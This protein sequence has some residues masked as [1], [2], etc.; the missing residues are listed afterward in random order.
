MIR[1]LVCAATLLAALGLTDRTA[2]AVRS[3]IIPETTARRHGLTRPWFTQIQLD[4]GRARVSSILLHEE[5]LYV[6]TD[7]AMVH[8]IDGETG[9]TLWTRQVGRPGHPSLTP[10]ANRDY[11]ACINGSHLYVCNRYN[12]D[13]LFEI[14]VGGAPGAGPAV[15]EKR[16]YVPMVNGLVIAYRLESL[17][18]P[19]YELGKV[20][21]GVTEEEKAALE[22]NR[23]ENLRLRQEYIPPLACQ[24]IGRTLVQP[25][26]TR[27]NPAEE[28]VAWPTDRGHLNVGRIDRNREDSFWVKYRLETDQEISAQPTYRP[29]NINDPADFGIIFAASRDGFVH[30]IDERNGQSL[31]RFSTGEPLVQPAVVVEDDV[32]VATQPGGIYCLDAN[33]GREKWWTPQIEQFLAVSK[34]RV[35]VT[36]KVGRTL[37]LNLKTGAR[38]DTIPLP[39]LPIKLINHRTDRI[40]L[41]T[42]T[43]LVQCL[44]ETELSEPI[45]H[46]EHR[47]KKMV[48]QPAGGQPQPGPGAAG[49]QPQPGGPQQPAGQDD[50]FGND[51][52]PFGGGQE[53]P[54]NPAGGGNQGQDP[55]GGGG[56]PFN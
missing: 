52:D 34:E 17:T 24:S 50:P 53:V 4:R 48:Q 46:G 28:Y 54:D 7:R 31:W 16:A 45:R 8:A 20:K 49:G 43:G 22:E 29:A 35:Y 23:R 3:S 37:T 15:S 1:S 25:L 56:N 38:L 11:L 32:F 18:D 10:G 27:Q 5:V 47:T 30:A 13:L 2:A 26:V 36:D 39:P 19:M 42:H 51:V 41:A 33:T 9:A 21:T 6:Q 55:L 12:G 14:E 40:Y 44:H